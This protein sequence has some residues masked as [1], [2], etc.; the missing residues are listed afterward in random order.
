MADIKITPT[1]LQGKLSTKISSTPLNIQQGQV[2]QTSPDL[3]RLPRTTTLRGEVQHQNPDGTTRIQTPR[4]A[5]DVK[6]DAPLP[7][8]QKV[9]IQL[10]S[11]SPPK[12]VIVQPA[13]QRASQPQAQAAPQPTQGQGQ[14]NPNTSSS[15]ATTTQNQTA[16]PNASTPTGQP[17]PQ[18]VQGQ[19]QPVNT[20]IET[21]R[22]LQNT[23][24]KA[25]ETLSQGQSTASQKNDTTQ[26]TP[27]LQ[28]S[29]KPLQTGQALRLTPLPALLQNPSGLKQLQPL[30][31]ANVIHT[32]IS[33][34]TNTAQT[35]SPLQIATPSLT[36]VA[37]LIQTPQITSPQLP[38]SLSLTPQTPLLAQSA[39][40]APQLTSI[41]LQPN[42]ALPT[43]LSPLQSL[44]NIIQSPQAGFTLTQNTS[45]QDA[46]VLNIQQP[47]LSNPPQQN[48]GTPLTVTQILK[49]QTAPATAN[50]QPSQILVQSTGQQTPDG[51]PIVQIIPHNA[52]T[53]PAS[54]PTFFAL[55][56]PAS[57]LSEGTQIVLQPSP[58]TTSQTPSAQS[59]P[60]LQDAFEELFLQL[61]PAQ[62]QTLLNVIP[63]PA[64]AGHQFTAAALLFIA[65]ARGGEISGWMGGRADQL[66]KN[67][68]GG[69]KEI[70]NKLLSEIGRSTARA[71]STDPQAPTATQN[72]PDWRGYTL[73]LLFGMDLTKIHLWTK[74]FGDDDS[75]TAA[76]DK[77]R[78]TR[79]IVDLEL[80]RMG[81]IQLDGLIQPYAK[82]LDLALKTQHNF[83]PDIRQYLRETWHTSLQSIDMTGQIDFQTL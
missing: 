3:S 44:Q 42:A 14:T 64:A 55:N 18:I 69:K 26:N 1:N 79:F 46:R 25:I 39:P 13:P 37:P 17:S 5:V 68:D 28:T 36:S 11:G 45:L 2:T 43:T 9:D 78:G 70:F 73:P 21:V 34:T 57:N 52:I 76:P 33:P 72:S 63:R 29:A 31:S 53:T 49:P 62:A 82:R 35:A 27:L 65:A 10:S 71:V 74:P 12:E 83:S 30:Q 66:L 24:Q 61:Q 75:E 47:I 19:A 4:G 80:S 20:A 23:A 77:A 50:I 54:A 56:Y 58:Q 6:L 41:A 48:I 8:G 60:P 59:W 32:V 51:H 15:N 38:T 22:N 7:Q 40:Q 81:N 67:L 16:Q